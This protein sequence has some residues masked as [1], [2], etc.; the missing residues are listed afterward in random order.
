MMGR[1]QQWCVRGGRVWKRWGDGRE[2]EAAA[3]GEKRLRRM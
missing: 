3:V 1:V 2:E